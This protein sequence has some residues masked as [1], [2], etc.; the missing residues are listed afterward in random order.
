VTERLEI[1]V[2]I[3]DLWHYHNMFLFLLRKT[4]KVLGL[5]TSTH[6]T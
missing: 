2:T 3:L 5:Y 4:K 6:Q 1:E